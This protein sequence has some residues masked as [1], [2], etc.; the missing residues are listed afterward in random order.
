MI[1][2][3]RRAKPVAVAEQN[4]VAAPTNQHQAI[5]IGLGFGNITRPSQ[6]SEG[7]PDTPERWRERRGP[8]HVVEYYTWRLA[9]RGRQN[10]ADLQ[11]GNIDR[12]G[13]NLKPVIYR[14]RAMLR[15][16]AAFNASNRRAGSFWLSN[17][18]KIRR[19]SKYELPAGQ[20]TVTGRRSANIC[21]YMRRVPAYK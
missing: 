2:S 16:P 11:E 1:A 17:E 4:T 6:H 9:W 15:S 19:R 21:S 7:R 14:F 10:C 5:Y 13:L 18:G 3:V 20:A 12:E 8:S